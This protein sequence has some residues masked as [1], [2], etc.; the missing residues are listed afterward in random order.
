MSEWEVFDSVV[1]RRQRLGSRFGHG[2]SELP[3]QGYKFVSRALS[4][5]DFCRMGHSVYR[6]VLCC[7]VLCCVLFCFVLFCFV[8]FCF[9]LFCFVLFCFIL[10]YFIL[11]YVRR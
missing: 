9:V 8:L 6:F 3:D 7:V 5:T 2:V 1:G 11:F 4:N 10:F